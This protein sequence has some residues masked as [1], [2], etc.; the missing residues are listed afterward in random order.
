MKETIHLEEND[1][2]GGLRF[3]GRYSLRQIF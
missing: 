1:L 2:F 3:K